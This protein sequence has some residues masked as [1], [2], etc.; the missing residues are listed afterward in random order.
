MSTHSSIAIV[1]ASGE[2]KS[3]Y[4]HW[5]G[6]PGHHGKLLVEHYNTEEKVKGFIALGGLSSL[7]ERP[8]PKEGEEHS[9]KNPVKDVTVAYHRDRAEPLEI[10][11]FKSLKEFEKNL[12]HL[13]ARYV[14]VW[15]KG[16]WYY[17][18]VQMVK[19]KSKATISLELLTRESY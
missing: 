14:Y 5:D 6:Y 15:H 12:D 10:Y 7:R 4:C 17:S 19:G 13:D 9:Y 8:A 1:E 18:Y 3:I 2:V 16:V 11:H